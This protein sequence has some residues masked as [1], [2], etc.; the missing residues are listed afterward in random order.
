MDHTVAVFLSPLPRTNRMLS[1]SSAKTCRLN[2]S[3]RQQGLPATDF[4]R[5]AGSKTGLT[6]AGHDGAIGSG[7]LTAVRCT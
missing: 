1:H 3:V 4:S 2:T 7:T 5:W 6:V